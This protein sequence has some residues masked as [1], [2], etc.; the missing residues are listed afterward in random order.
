MISAQN[1]EIPHVKNLDGNS[2]LF[3]AAAAG[4][5]T[6]TSYTVQPEL[7]RIATDL[8]ASLTTT[9]AA[10]VGLCRSVGLLNLSAEPGGIPYQFKPTALLGVR[11]AQRA[12]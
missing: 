3:L 12:K 2:V 4:V 9:R 5:A 1:H 8:G 11:V 6:S 10:A 7:S